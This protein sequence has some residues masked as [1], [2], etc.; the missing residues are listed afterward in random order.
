[1]L[2]KKFGTALPWCDEWELIPVASGANALTLDWIFKAANEHRAPLTRLAVLVLGRLFSWDLRFVH[3]INLALLALG[4]LALI[5]A[6]RAVRGRSALSDAFLCLLVLTPWQ[7]QTVLVYCYGYAMALSALCFG[8]SA[9]LT[10]WPLRSLGRLGIYFGLL[11]GISLSAGPAGN[12]WAIGL[13]GVVV[14]GWLEPKPRSWKIGGLAGTAVVT[15]VSVVM[16]LSIPHVNHHDTFRADTLKTFVTA[17]AQLSVGWLGH[18][19]ALLWPWIF[20]V[21][22]FPFVVL[23]ARMGHLMLK[24]QGPF[25]AA[26]CHWKTWIDLTIPFTAMLSVAGMIGYG[27]GN[28][29]PLWQ[30][31]YCT[32]LMPIGLMCYLLLVRVRTPGVIPNCLVLA[33]MFSVGWNW[34]VVIGLGRLWHE[35]IAAAEGALKDSSFPLTLWAS[36]HG[37]AVGSSQNKN[38]LMEYLLQLRS[39]RLSVFKKGVKEISPGMGWPITLEAENGRL[40]GNIQ[41]VYDRLAT[42]DHALGPISLADAAGSAAY[43]V[44]VPAAGSYQLCCRID[45]QARSHVINLQIDEGPI[46]TTAIGASREYSP[47]ILGPFGMAAGK[48]VLHLTIPKPGLRLDFLE[49]IPLCPHCAVPN[50]YASQEW[51]LLGVENR[52]ARKTL[53]RLLSLSILYWAK[54]WASPRPGREAECEE[55]SSV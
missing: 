37:D 25:E 2:L 6:V 9:A 32:L 55:I 31:L 54:H 3:F 39:A 53:N 23:L 26:D 8:I 40:C 13:C 22:L 5:G 20:L 42:G 7:Y 1:V 34:P 17:T 48:H 4:A 16:L 11:L 24:K 35:P 49:L 21:F 27:R 33:M 14:R 38:H 45:P 36:C 47:Y 15:A 18:P 12:L 29:S 41:T 50:A 44:E 43:E 30:S 51:P 28:Y 52:L 46:L 19:V 10:G